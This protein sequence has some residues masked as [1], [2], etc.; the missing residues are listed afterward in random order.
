MC[1][2]TAYWSQEDE[3]PILRDISNASII[4]DTIELDTLFGEKKILQGKIRQIDFMDSKIFI[5]Q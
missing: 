2:A 5:E 1:L 4:S 3:Q